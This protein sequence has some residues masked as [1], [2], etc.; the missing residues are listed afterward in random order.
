MYLNIIC[1][2]CHT[3]YLMQKI[4]S[5]IRHRPGQRVPYPVRPESIVLAKVLIQ[6]RLQQISA[7]PHAIALNGMAFAGSDKY[8]RPVRFPVF[9]S[10]YGSRNS[11]HVLVDKIISHTSSSKQD[12][13]SS[14]L[15]NLFYYGF[16]PCIILLQVSV[17]ALPHFLLQKL[18][19]S[20]IATL[21]SGVSSWY[22][23]L[24]LILFYRNDSFSAMQVSPK[25]T[26]SGQLL[27]NRLHFLYI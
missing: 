10:P 17:Q 4:S 23:K 1:H 16:F 14:P 12:K 15:A 19:S 25:I 24:S 22:I 13:N 2:P 5:S 27:E 3:K 9:S 18:K 6:I 11:G 7:C 20:I 26:K 8:Q 21:I